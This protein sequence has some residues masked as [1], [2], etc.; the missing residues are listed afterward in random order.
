MGTDVVCIGK[1]MGIAIGVL[2]R[3]SVEWLLATED[4]LQQ[5]DRM[6]KIKVFSYWKQSV[7]QNGAQ[8]PLDGIFFLLNMAGNWS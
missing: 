3:V 2:S 8:I 4:D 1:R 7:Q 6:K 5:A